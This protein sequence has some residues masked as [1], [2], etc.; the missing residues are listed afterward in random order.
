MTEFLLRKMCKVTG[1]GSCYEAIQLT[2]RRS[3]IVPA[4]LFALAAALLMSGCTSTKVTRLDT[5]T[6]KVKSRTQ[7]TLISAMLNGNN[8]TGE[9][10]AQTDPASRQYNTLRRKGDT[11]IY[12]TYNASMRKIA[13]R[14][15]SIAPE[16]CDGVHYSYA[17]RGDRIAFVDSKKRR[18]VVYDMA[19]QTEKI[20]HVPAP[21]PFK[22]KFSVAWSNDM[23]WISD[24][25]ILHLEGNAVYIA[26]VETGKWRAINNA[27]KQENWGHALSPDGTRLAFADGK[28]TEKNKYIPDEGVVK[29]WDVGKGTVVKTIAKHKMGK[30]N[31]MW[32]SDSKELAYVVRGVQG[33]E[34]R[35]YN[36]ATGKERT[37][38]TFPE[39]YTCRIRSFQNGVV[40]Y[41]T[42]RDGF[43]ILAELYGKKNF[44]FIDSRTGETLKKLRLG[45]TCYNTLHPLDNDGKYITET[46][47][48]G[49]EIMVPFVALVGLM[50]L[51]GWDGEF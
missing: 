27:V 24:S 21:V 43:N 50:A 40:G 41:M 46:M 44:S 38:R 8:D 26:N 48:F 3:A 2:A 14:K 34:I 29:I 6:G 13:E 37:L 9:G 31:P 45:G 25:E 4:L 19:A 10:L 39:G 47:H 5:Q 32:S 33:D 15:M 23:E 36:M 51:R 17:A 35:V 28:P 1:A 22:S 7:V 42:E 16:L 49:T 12:R 18:I 11:L 20:V 30:S